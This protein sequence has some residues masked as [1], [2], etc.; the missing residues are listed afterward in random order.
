MFVISNVGIDKIDAVK[1][2]SMLSMIFFPDQ[3]KF[4]LNIQIRYDD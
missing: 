2:I 4:E 3:H 1:K